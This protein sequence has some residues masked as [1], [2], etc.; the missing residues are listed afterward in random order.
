MAVQTPPETTTHTVR[1]R[2]D[3]ARGD[4]DPLL[5]LLRRRAGDAPDVPA[6]ELEAHT[7]VRLIWI[8]VMW[9]VGI[10]GNVE[11]STAF[12]PT[13]AAGLAWVLFS[14]T[15]QRRHADEDAPFVVA[16]GDVV[17]AGAL[18]ALSGGLDSG[19]RHVAYV[20]P[21]AS[22]FANGPR[23]V[24]LLGA[25]LGLAYTVSAG[26]EVA[27]GVDGAVQ[28]FITFW[29]ALG[30]ATTAAALLAVSRERRDL[31]I[32]DLL[33][34]RSMLAADLVASEERERRRLADELHDDALQL[35]IAA[36]QDADDVA[37]GDEDA[38]G[39]LNATLAEAVVRLRAL[40][41]E[42]HPLVSTVGGVDQS[43][44]SICERHARRG[45]YEWTVDVDPRAIGY[46]DELLLGVAR[47][48]IVN[49]SKHAHAEQLRVTVRADNNWVVL[50]VAD[51]GIGIAADRAELARR[52][53]HVG[54]A[55]C[56]ERVRVAGGHLAMDSG[57]PG[58]GTVVRVA[59]PID[60]LAVA[61]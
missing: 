17:I 42:V 44:R 27:D 36:R 7:V 21:F 39:P 16:Y 45:G 14:E 30:W 29:L 5:P 58:D 23:R 24:A 54:L 2:F 55:S 50:T 46:C 37:A 28:T 35:V 61:S 56:T 1:G 49:V 25:G 26:H 9:L 53:G 32:T 31:Q 38:I 12:T 47:E 8:P 34:T 15:W 19:A 33:A 6:R 10:L 4:S 11:V 41:S 60:V 59:V 3:R 22:A 51:D 43:L 18:F 40:V 13:A 48:L 57:R 52:D 20:L